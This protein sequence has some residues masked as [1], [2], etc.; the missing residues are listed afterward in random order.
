MDAND[1]LMS[2]GIKSIKWKDEPIGYTVLGTIV[3][4]PKAEQM[5]KFESTELDFWPSGDPKMQIV[6]TIQTELRDPSDSLDDGKRKLHIPPR[7]MR[8]VREAIQRV[9][10][11]GLE[12]GGRLAVRR[13]G[14]TG[15]T[16]SPFEFAA[17]YARPTLDPASLMKDTGTPAQPAAPMLTQPAAPASPPPTAAASLGIQQTA[18]EIPPPPGMDPVKWAAL[19]DVQKQAVLAAMAPTAPAPF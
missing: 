14:G 3:D 7:M 1:L 15:A 10:G 17:E 11:P 2:G 4:P 6:V 18:V 5:T 12:V 8:P 19:P 16:G 9:N 13:T